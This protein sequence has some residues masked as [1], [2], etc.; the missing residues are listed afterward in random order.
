MKMYLSSFRLGNNPER[1]ANMISGNKRVA[2][3]G[4]AMDFVIKEDR[5]VSIQKDFVEL[6]GIGI[7]A[8]ELDLR[9]YFDKPE[10]LKRIMNK[11]DAVWVRGGNT[12]V[13]RQAMKKSGFDEIIKE[14]VKDPEFVYG[15]YS[16]GVS[17]LSPDLHGLELCDQPNIKAEG[18]GEMNTVWEGLGILDYSVAPHYK[19]AH[20]ESEAVD[21]I[22][23]YFVDNGIK[24]KAISDGDVIIVE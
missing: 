12:F 11:Y 1:L 19:S 4:N 16:A 21:Q 6:K 7:K 13:L 9:K 8:E 20:P 15:G 14:K 22:V 3:I 23:K 10:E 5:F 24:Y 17:V 2:L 18:Y